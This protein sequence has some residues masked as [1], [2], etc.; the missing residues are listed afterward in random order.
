LPVQ[1]RSQ[2][3]TRQPEDE[4]KQNWCHVGDPAEHYCHLDSVPLELPKSTADIPRVEHQTQEPG[5]KIIE[6]FY[7][8][9]LTQGK[10]VSCGIDS[11]SITRKMASQNLSELGEKRLARSLS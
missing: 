11:K 6:E 2:I 8:L 5:V 1:L 10:R 9:A 7:E 3:P 4:Q